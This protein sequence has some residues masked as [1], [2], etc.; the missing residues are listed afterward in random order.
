M[1]SQRGLS[2]GWVTPWWH[3]QTAGV[4]LVS[5][6]VLHVGIEQ[7]FISNSSVFCVISENN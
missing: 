7:P 6:A 4:S 5:F 3:R 2:P 1:L